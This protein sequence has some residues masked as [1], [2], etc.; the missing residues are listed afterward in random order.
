MQAEVQQYQVQQQQQ[1]L[2]ELQ[3]QHISAGSVLAAAAAAGAAPQPAGPCLALSQLLLY[4]VLLLQQVLPVL[5]RMLSVGHASAA[6][7]AVSLGVAIEQRLQAVVQQLE[8]LGQQAGAYQ[9]QQDGL[10]AGALQLGLQLVDL[11]CFLLNDAAAREAVSQQLAVHANG[12]VAEAG[13]YLTHSQ[14]WQ[15]Q[16]HG[17]QPGPA[18]MLQQLTLALQHIQHTLA[19]AMQLA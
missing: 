12:F 14:Q 4:V 19:Q 10:H 13:G 3:R 9:Q 17:E 16:Q 8:G 18:V 2:Q 15:Q 7:D 11:C 5:G 1:L 6:C